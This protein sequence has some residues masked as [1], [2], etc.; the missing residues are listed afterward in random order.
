MFAFTCI[1]AFT[2]SFILETSICCYN[3]SHLKQKFNR[4]E[5]ISTAASIYKYILNIST[6]QRASSRLLNVSDQMVVA[7]GGAYSLFLYYLCTSILFFIWTIVYN[8][9]LTINLHIIAYFFLWDFLFFNLL[10]S[11]MYISMYFVSRDLRKSRLL[12]LV[13]LLQ[14]LNWHN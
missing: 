11:M 5:C 13:I 1:L 8:L 14:L 6:R 7:G 2:V 3:H 4:S 12:R 10:I 9:S